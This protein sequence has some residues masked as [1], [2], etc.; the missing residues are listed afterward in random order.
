MKTFRQII[1]ESGRLVRYDRLPKS[2]KPFKPKSFLYR[3]TGDGTGSGPESTWGSYPKS[4]TDILKTGLFAGHKGH[5]APYTMPRNIRW[6]RVGER[7][8][9]EKPTLI[10]SKKDFKRLQK[11]GRS[12]ASIYNIKQGFK[13]TSGG[14]FFAA[15]ENI[16]PIKQEIVDPL[17]TIRKS[18]NIRTVRNLDSIKRRLVRSEINHDAEGNFK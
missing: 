4:E 7:K 5:A 6:I 15:R 10:M 1:I 8:G 13:K 3:F 16:P 11:S 17:K 9:D 12:V 18:H 2:G 14:E